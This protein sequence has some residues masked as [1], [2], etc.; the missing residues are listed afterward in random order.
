MSQQVPLRRLAG[1]FATLLACAA[2]LPAGLAAAQEEQAEEQ[3]AG[4]RSQGYYTADTSDALPPI[5]TR[6]FPPGVVCIV[7]PEA[8]SEDTEPITR[9]I[10]EA[11]R[12]V[13]IPGGPVQPVAPGTLPVGMLGGQERYASVLAFD[14][15]QPP[16]G[17]EVAH[18][19]LVLHEATPA[20][21]VE[22]PAFRAAVRAMIS[23]IADEPSPEPARVVLANAATGDEPL[24]SEDFPGVEACP[25]LDAWEAEE[26]QP[27]DEQ[28]GR[29]CV[30]GGTG[31]ADG[32]GA[33][34]FDLTF[35][36][37]GWL[38]GSL[39][40]EGLILAPQGP[41]NLEYGD[42][43]Y[44]TNFLLAFEGAEAD[45]DAQPMLRVAFAQEPEPFDDDGGFDDDGFDDETA[46]EGV[47][48]GGFEDD[49]GGFDDG[50]ASDDGLGAAE[51]PSLEEADEPRDAEEAPE[52][53][54]HEDE[55]EETVAAGA[56]RPTPEDPWYLWLLLPVG[57]TGMWWYSRV[58]GTEPELAGRGAG[59]LRRLVD[60]TPGIA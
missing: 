42:P 50:D 7:V 13:E 51:E 59:A 38:D 24:V 18:L 35:A 2:V 19:E 47:E 54:V 44:S 10:D 48:G 27:A 56:R 5:L 36:A 33:W 14:V 23:Q 32:D 9:P 28:P 21:S 57:A 31:E 22:S 37:M 41:E 20:T 4:V 43:D 29:D 26:N 40:M 53:E 11:V 12:E 17:Y 6:E 45:D 3:P 58:L 52:P 49:G 15:P 60:R 16:E 55:A 8:C 30:F 34:T 39:P 46:D 25:V 1:V